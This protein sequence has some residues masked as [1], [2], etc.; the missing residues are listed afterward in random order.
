M[1][2]YSKQYQ[3]RRVFTLKKL[4]AMPKCKYCKNEQKKHMKDKT[5]M[6]QYIQASTLPTINHPIL[7][8][9]CKYKIRAK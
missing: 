1:D 8:V 7:V 9:F 5:G 2:Y 4:T 6:Y 3:L